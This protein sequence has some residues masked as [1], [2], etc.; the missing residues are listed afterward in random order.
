MT[1]LLHNIFQIVTI[2]VKYYYYPHFTVAKT[3]RESL[4]R[5]FKVKRLIND[6][7]G[8]R[9]PAVLWSENSRSQQSCFPSNLLLFTGKLSGNRRELSFRARAPDG[10]ETPSFLPPSRYPGAQRLQKH[11][12]PTAGHAPSPGP[13]RHARHAGPASRPGVGGD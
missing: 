5:Q 6:R 13:P 4:S 9:S 3:K 10:Q 8:I 1:R 12:P 7:V 2:W 11:S